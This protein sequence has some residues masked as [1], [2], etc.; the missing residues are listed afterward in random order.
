MNSNQGLGL[1]KLTC[2][3]IGTTLASGVFSMSSDMA[4]GGAGTYAVL[5][6]W[7]IAGAG[8]YAMAMCF[9]RLSVIKPHLT[10]GIY[11][12]AKEGYGEYVGFNSA[13]GYWV[14]AILSQ[15]SFATL[16]FAAL[17]NFFPLF[18]DGNNIPSI[19]GA[20][21]IVWLFTFMVMY[22]VQE[23]VTI[24]VVIVIAKLLPI[25]A[26]I[27]F[28]L[29]LGA[30]DWDVFLSNFNGE[31]TGL[32]LSEQVLKTTYTTVWIFTGIEGA[33]V[34]SARAKNTATAGK[35]TE[36]SFL[37]LFVL[38]VLISVLSMGI[39]PRAQLAELPNP[40]MA[41]LMEYIVGPWGRTLINA[42]VII[43]IIGAMFA[44]TLVIA[45]S[46]YA[47]AKD[48]AFPSF[49]TIENRKKA[50]V[51]SL[52]L[53]A[54]IIQILLIVVY[55]QSSTY[56]TLYTLATSAIMIPFVLSAMYCLKTTIHDNFIHENL[57]TPKVWIISIL[58]TVYGFWMLFATGLD[59]VVISA[60]IF[61]P[62][63]LVYLWSRLQAR[64]KI[65][66]TKGD[67]ASFVIIL[68]ALIVA[69]IW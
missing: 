14:S 6:G 26:F 2:F 46:V 39:M 43:S 41:A 50:P 66:E 4:A 9:N 55:F 28:A 64:R 15:V 62:G 21:I 16:L 68:V 57:V 17:G 33:V 52:I 35:A 10:S 37:A 69:L 49:I 23:A 40:S 11:S 59:N 8:M 19:V 58:G 12:Y 18:G 67:I 63:F 7:A 51:A 24:N 32:P 30:F 5:I 48:G 31:D 65:F 56:Q 34:I 44:Y 29:F 25:A 38:Y 3:A 27:V 45:D 22:G 20:S 54:A 36:L 47:P 1:F 60:F 61:G 53:S 42:G 13:W